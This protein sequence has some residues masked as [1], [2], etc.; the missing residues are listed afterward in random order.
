M[1]LDIGDVRRAFGEDEFFPFFQPQVALSTGQLAGFEALARWNHQLLGAISPDAFVPIVQNCGFVNRLTQRLLEK[2]FASA[3]LLPESLML[4]INISPLQ[5]LDVTLPGQ[6]AAAAELGGFSLSRLTVEMTE[7]ALFEDLSRAREVARRLKTFDCK[8]ALDNF[9][10]GQSSLTH[11]LAVP[12]DEVKL[13]RSFI[14]T[15]TESRDSRKI[16]SAVVAL[17]QNLGLT[18][19][20]EGVETEEETTILR[21]FGCD[22]AQGWLFGKP[23][24]A[25]E[26]PRLVREATKNY[27]G[28]LLALAS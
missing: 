24:P 10:K 5:I 28:F 23:A 3:H 16:V 19:V 9:G 25:A 1:F 26:I 22:L 17:G 12:F 15:V 4:S 21:E 18:T 8:L 13:D 11:L 27:P 7:E 14:R 6:I 2:T 20:A